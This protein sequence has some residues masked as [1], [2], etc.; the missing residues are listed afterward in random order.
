[1]NI[2]NPFELF[3]LK[4][5]LN[6]DQTL[7]DQAFQCVQL[8]CHPDQYT[9]PIDKQAALALSAKISTQ[10]AALK[11]PIG[12]LNAILKLHNLDSIENIAKMYSDIETMQD[13]FAMQES[14]ID[15]KT[16][17]DTAEI[18]KL[19]HVI[20]ERLTA[21]ELAFML[22]HNDNNLADLQKQA[23]RFS[24]FIKFQD[25]MLQ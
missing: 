11:T 25:N 7:L 22:A 19:S 14:L 2:N 8:L 23:V 16:K 17:G 21:I 6:I 20:Q 15:L 24:Y 13:I 1:M 9:C 12:C 10:Y 18:K 3:S 5:Q 4:P